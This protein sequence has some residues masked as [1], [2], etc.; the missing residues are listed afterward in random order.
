MGRSAGGRFIRDAVP[1]SQL[2]RTLVTRQLRVQVKRSTF[3][4]VWPATAPFFLLALYVFVFRSV[5]RIPI[6]NYSEFLF[7]GLLPWTF[8][9]QSLGLAIG[10]LSFE[11]DLI[12]RTRFPYA[13]LPLSAIGVIAIP[14][15]CDLCIF[16]AYLGVRGHLTWVVFAL[17]LC[18]I[19]L[20]LLTGSLGMIIALIDVYNR[21]LRKVLNNLLTL[22]F[23]LVPV[24]YRQNMVPHQLL[25]LRSIDPMN[26]IVG[27][28]RQVLYNGRLTRPLHLALMEIICVVAFSLSLIA[29]SYLSRDLAKDI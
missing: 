1:L 4:M 9:S 13:I 6:R 28:F 21:D 10:S 24:V 17:P 12:R 7:S 25:V 27:S 14:F 23:F 16:V 15:V 5:F 8:L 20:L 19:P 26:M 3:G 29:F 2:L 18:V 11:P 22:W